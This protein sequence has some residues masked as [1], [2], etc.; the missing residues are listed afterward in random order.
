MIIAD[1]V[2]NIYVGK[3][4]KTSPDQRTIGYI[5]TNMM[6]KG[7]LIFVFLLMGLSFSSVSQPPSKELT[8]T[9]YIE[10]YKDLAIKE[11]ERSGIPASITLAQ[12]ILE[13]NCGN[14]RLAREA[15]NHFGIKCHSGWE[16]KTI[17]EDDDEKNEC[18]RKYKTV[19]DSYKDH[20]DF[21]QAKQRYAFLFELKNTDYKGWAEGLKKAGYATNPKYPALL[22]KIIEENK[23]N[24]LDRMTT[25]DLAA[26]K[27]HLE[28][29]RKE[30]KGTKLADADNY[31]I[32]PYGRK[33][34]INNR[35]KY[36]ISEEND[37]YGKIAESFD[38]LDWEIY[39]YN[40]L[41]RDAELN[42]GQMVYLQPK[43]NKAEPG[44]ETHVV[45][46]GDNLYFISQAYGIKLSKLYRLNNMKDGD[47]VKE[48]DTI[49]LRRRK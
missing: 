13:S 17:H 20:T 34:M 18:F 23:L 37:T 38:L 30:R 1:F 9:E 31:S 21:L 41:R 33:V 16:G 32:N 27:K 19:Y 8:R 11:Q 24:E 40:E 4:F 14:S 10:I 6:M 29:S 22:I 25:K 26:D 15:N 46:K 5:F 35:I 3:S 28:K 48:G 43:R 7:F 42:P 2:V 36:I 44:K 45:K 49:Q 47:Q 39:R 12:G